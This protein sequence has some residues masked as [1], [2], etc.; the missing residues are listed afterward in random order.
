MTNHMNDTVSI[1]HQL[2]FLPGGLNVYRRSLKMHIL[3]VSQTEC[4]LHLVNTSL[5]MATRTH[6][7]RDACLL[8][9]H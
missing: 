2:E 3:T 8:Q 9:P 7:L 4:Q 1:K 5:K 6:R